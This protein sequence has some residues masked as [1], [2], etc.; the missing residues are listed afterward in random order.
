MIQKF[1]TMVL[2]VALIVTIIIGIINFELF[3]LIWVRILVA[4]III[5]AVVVVVRSLFRLK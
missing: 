2:A 5:G 3:L 1:L 4:V